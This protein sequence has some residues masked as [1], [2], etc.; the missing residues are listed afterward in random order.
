[1]HSL[2]SGCIG[3]INADLTNNRSYCK[4]YVIKS[5]VSKLTEYS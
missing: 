4:L 3:V 2:F 1:V 5:V